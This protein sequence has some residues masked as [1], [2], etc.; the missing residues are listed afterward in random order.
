MDQ[1][2]ITFFDQVEQRQSAVGVVLG[3]VDHQPQVVLDHLL[4]RR[5]IPGSRQPRVV[6]LLLRA[7]QLVVSDLVEVELGHIGEQIGAGVV[8]LQ[9]ILLGRHKL[10]GVRGGPH[11]EVAVIS[12]SLR[13]ILE[14]ID[15]LAEAADLEVQ[16]RLAGN[17]SRPSRR[18][19]AL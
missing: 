1:A 7:E 12:A 2:E 14:G 4:A 9:R 10:V 16:G 17:P 5:E 19:S 3:D 18:S 11:L 15:R 13:K 6:Q 8:L